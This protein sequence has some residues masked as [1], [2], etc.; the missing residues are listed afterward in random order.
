[1]KKFTAWALC[2]ALILTLV[3]APVQAAAPDNPSKHAFD[4]KIIKRIQVDNIYRHIHHL[5]EVIGP[6]V[7]GTDAELQ[8]VEYLAEEFERYGYDDVQV[9]PFTFAGGTT[10]YNVIATKRSHPNH[11]TGQIIVVGAHHDSVRNAPGAND[12]ASGTGVLLEMARV[13][14]NM[15]TDTE[16]RFIAFGAEERGLV[17]SRH[18]ASTLTK[19]EVERTAAMFQMDMI[20]SRDAGNLTMFTVDGQKNTVTDLAASAG[21]RVSQKI[22]PFSMLGRSDHVPFYELGIPAALFIHTPLEPWYHSP[23]DTIDKISKEKL[24]DVAYI[25]GSALYRKNNPP[26]LIGGGFLFF[27]WWRLFHPLDEILQF[28]FIPDVGGVVEGFARVFIGQ[29]LLVYISSGEVVGIQIADSPPLGFGP[30]EMGVPQ[31]GGNFS[32]DFLF[33]CIHRLG[34]PLI[35]GIAFGSSGNVDHRFRQGNLGFGKANMLYRL[36]CGGGDQES[37]GIGHAYVFGGVDKHP[38]GDEAGVLSGMNHLGQ[39]I[40]GGIGIGPPHAFDKS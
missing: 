35:D 37:P 22:P 6:R 1:M 4:N 10:S 24:Q 29:V 38:P 15:P 11:D 12:D 34:D 21:V 39:I 7:A 14:K 23:D 40:Q 33:H 27:I 19:D 17:G 5:S 20:G 18:Y 32:P 28:F 36:G 16:I 3:Q 9:Q 8:T 13:L 30:L 31:M 2:I 26:P 25:V